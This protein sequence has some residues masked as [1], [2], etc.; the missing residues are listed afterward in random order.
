[1]IVMKYKRVLIWLHSSWTG[2][3]KLGQCYWSESTL[4]VPLEE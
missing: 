4:T 1:M 3:L 2:R